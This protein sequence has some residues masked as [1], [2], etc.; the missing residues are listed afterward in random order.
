MNVAEIAQKLTEWIRDQVAASGTKGI[1]LGLSGGIDSAVVAALAQRACGTNV[2]GL[3]MPCH[4]DPQDAADAHLVADAL[5]IETKT[6]DLG[7][8]YDR[9]LSVMGETSGER[10]LALA[11]IKPRLRMITNYYHAQK[12]GYLVA[13]TGNR[14]ELTI[15]Y[16]TK[17]GDSGCDLLPIGGLVKQQVWELAEYL[18]IP[19]KIIA[20]AP[21]AGLWPDQTD[22]G[23]MGLT[24]AELDHYILTGEADPVSQ[25]RIEQM[26]SRSAHKRKMPPIAE[27]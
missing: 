24:Y 7:A 13:G 1:V 26:K 9:M 20:K 27:L 2:L 11:N 15:G 19:E 10:S 4:S 6:V 21:S 18:A 17:H 16:F 12:L 14:S 23:E 5:K 3:I 8:A 25:A 22:E